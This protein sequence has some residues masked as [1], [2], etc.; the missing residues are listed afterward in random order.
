MFTLVGPVEWFLEG[1][2]Y[3]QENTNIS[4]EDPEIINQMTNNCY[5][6]ADAKLCTL[7]FDTIL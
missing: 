2:R 5:I 6:F 7:N 3:Q 4:N 1:G